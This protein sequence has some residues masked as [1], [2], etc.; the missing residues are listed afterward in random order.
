M[1]RLNDAWGYF[2]AVGIILTCIAL[3]GWYG[4]APSLS[5]AGQKPEPMTLVVEGLLTSEWS[6]PI[7]LPEGMTTVTMPLDPGSQV[8]IRPNGLDDAIYEKTADNRILVNGVEQQ[9]R[10]QRDF[11]VKFIQIRAAPGSEGKRY[12]VYLTKA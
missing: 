7:E 12:A 6:A 2:F 11:A 9:G 5:V 3:V 4:G 8:Q 10:I 1:K